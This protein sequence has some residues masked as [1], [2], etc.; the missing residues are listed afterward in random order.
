MPSVLVTGAAGFVGRHIAHACVSRGWDVIAFDVKPI[1]ADGI[2][3]LLGSLTNPSE[4]ARAVKG[5]DFV[6]HEGAASSSMMFEPDPSAGVQVNVMGGLNLLEACKQAGVARLVYASTS[7]LYGSLPVPWRE[8][9]AIP[10]APNAYAAS[11][12]AFEY[13]AKVYTARGHLDTVGLRYFSVYGPGEESKGAYANM[14]SQFLWS[15]RKGEHPVVYGDGNQTRDFTYVDDVV[16]A[17]LLALRTEA[18]GEIFNVGTGHETSINDLVQTLS[19]LLGQDVRPLYASNPIHNYVIRT[20]AD[21]TKAET[22]LGF[23][24]EVSFREGVA[25]LVRQTVGA[26]RGGA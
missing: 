2:R 18:T 11:K 10:L 24:A 14:V 5:V 8:D 26:G 4:V 1:E 20:L 13:L 23:R 16:A 3:P 12:L 7:S 17:N 21:T 9:M 6:F 25:R 15:M 19:G 22:L